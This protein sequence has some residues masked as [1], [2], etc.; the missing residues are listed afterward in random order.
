MAEGGAT[1]GPSRWGGQL[2]AKREFLVAGGRG[3]FWERLGASRGVTGVPDGAMWGQRRCTEKSL[4]MY[5]CTDISIYVQM[6][7]IDVHGFP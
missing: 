1:M 4:Y 5:L 7:N 3:A 6:V 2:G